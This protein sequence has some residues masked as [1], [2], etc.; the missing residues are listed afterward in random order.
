[1]S[2]NII[3]LGEINKRID[4]IKR[5]V[6]TSLAGFEKIIEINP[7]LKDILIRTTSNETATL[8]DLCVQ[9]DEIMWEIRYNE[10]GKYK[11]KM[12]VYSLTEYDPIIQR[13]K[14]RPA[15]LIKK[16]KNSSVQS[17]SQF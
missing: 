16:S 13:I 2:D 15:L 3:K 10:L 4:D 7:S 8:S 1:M 14:K 11:D 12:K 9:R 5:S 17:Q 6:G